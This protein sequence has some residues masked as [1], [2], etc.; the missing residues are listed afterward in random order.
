M[1]LAQRMMLMVVLAIDV[2]LVLFPPFERRA[3]WRT[4]HLGYHWLPFAVFSGARV[5]F[6]ALAAEIMIVSVI[7]FTAFFAMRGNPGEH[8]AAVA[9]RLSSLGRALWKPG[10][11]RLLYVVAAVV[12]VLEIVVLVSWWS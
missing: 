4:S 1:N 6:G 3:G 9:S 12:L 5:N 8:A 10:W 11:R 2:L 7:G